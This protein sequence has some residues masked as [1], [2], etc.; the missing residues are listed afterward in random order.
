MIGKKIING[1]IIAISII[2]IGFVVIFSLLPNV[3][4]NVL[5]TI[6]GFIIPIC[7][8]LITMIVEIKKAEDLQEKNKIRDF[9]LRILFIIYCILLI[10]ILFLNNEYRMSGFQSININTFSREHFE[11]INIIPFST[12]IGY[13]NGLLFED[14]SMS[15]VIIN[16]VTN[17]LLFAPMG[18]FIPLLFKDKITNIKQFIIL[19]IIL[20]LFVEI[21]QFITYRGSTDIDDII[22]NTI[23]AII[24]YILMK[25][26]LAKITLEKAL[27]IAE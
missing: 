6:G 9:W 7:M 3:V 11:T 15:I 2:L 4:L 27:D 16:L 8:I 13:I 12:I 23:G 14:A 22:L 21:L 1:I 20:S 10:T 5:V 17:L 18:F 26:R 25:T 19:I 24:I